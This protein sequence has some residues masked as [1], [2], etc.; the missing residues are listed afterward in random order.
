MSRLKPIYSLTLA[1]MLAG[2]LAGCA[3]FPARG[4]Q[5]PADAKIT[6]DVEAQ[7]NQMSDLGPPGSIKVQ[8][9]DRVVYLN[10]QVDVGV[11]KRTAESAVREVSGVKQVTDDIVVAHN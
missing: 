4:S 3:G 1:S 9:V 8:T 10:G 11:E 7:L 5:D 6:A 2:V